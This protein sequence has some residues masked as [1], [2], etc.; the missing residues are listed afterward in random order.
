MNLRQYYSRIH[1]IIV[2]KSEGADILKRNVSVHV[3]KARW[4]IDFRKWSIDKTKEEAR[5]LLNIPLD[6][7]VIFSSSRLT[8]LKQIDKLLE[9]LRNIAHDSYICYISGHGAESYEEELRNLVREFG[10]QDRVVFV[11]YVDMDTL[12]NYYLAADLFIS[13]SI[14]E[15][16]PYSSMLA[17]ALERPI[18]TTDT[19]VMSEILKEKGVGCILPVNDYCVWEK[20]I[21]KA[22]SGRRIR[23]L[24][25][26][27]VLDMFN[28]NCVA[29]DYAEI[30][31][32]VIRDFRGGEK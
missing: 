19:G 16:G 20:Q 6:R 11:G 2:L 3:H 10:V 25:R 26:S 9:V 32:K 14:S 21:G 7:Y 29:K 23:T 8:S 30:Y 15:A 24:R 27:E 12:R 17:A 31:K 18:M 4:G 22:I 28:W 5:E 1:D 13:T